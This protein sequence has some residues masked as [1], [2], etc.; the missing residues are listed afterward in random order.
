MHMPMLCPAC[1]T[2]PAACAALQ[3]SFLVSEKELGLRQ[4]LRTMG[5]TDTAYW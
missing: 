2:L 3:I 5:M 4:A 1:S